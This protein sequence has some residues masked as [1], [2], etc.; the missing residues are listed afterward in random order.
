MILDH[1]QRQGP[2]SIS[3]GTRWADGDFVDLPLKRRHPLLD[4]ARESSFDKQRFDLSRRQPD[5]SIGQK[6]TSSIRNLNVLE[7]AAVVRQWFHA[8][9]A[10]IGVRPYRRAAP[11][12]EIHFSWS[13]RRTDILQ[14]HQ[15]PSA[16]N[17]ALFPR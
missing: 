1:R 8:Q 16:G 9:A 11:A 14:H 12:I 2:V 13:E 15:R 10:T 3:H 5:Q 4:I 6:T 17:A 7:G